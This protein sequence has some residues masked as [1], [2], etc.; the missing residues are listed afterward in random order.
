MSFEGELAPRSALVLATR[1]EIDAT[2]TNH[3]AFIITLALLLI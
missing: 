1:Y 3:V 2:V